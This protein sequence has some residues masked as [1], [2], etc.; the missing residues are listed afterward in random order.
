MTQ[1]FQGAV[2]ARKRRGGRGVRRRGSRWVGF[3][4][5]VGSMAFNRRQT[6]NRLRQAYCE[7]WETSTAEFAQK[8]NLQGLIRSTKRKPS[9][10]DPADL[11]LTCLKG[12]RMQRQWGK[13]DRRFL[14]FKSPRFMC[15]RGQLSRENGHDP[16]PYQ[17]ASV[18]RYRNQISFELCSKMC[19]CV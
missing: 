19:V 18:R 8:E 13:T 9:G 1:G 15:V 12:L 7:P 16:I 14:T 2:C 17:L 10:S 3:P 11:T 6:F 4:T 5:R